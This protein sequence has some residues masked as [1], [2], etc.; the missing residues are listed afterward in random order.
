[1]RIP[2]QV[3]SRGMPREAT[4][5][6]NVAPIEDFKSLPLRCSETLELSL[7]YQAGLKDAVKE[8]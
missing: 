6:A 5:T 7:V 1:M 8:A 3:P 4:N 2:V